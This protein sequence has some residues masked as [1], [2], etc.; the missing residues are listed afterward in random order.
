MIIDI[1][2]GRHGIADAVVAGR[3]RRHENFNE[4][5]VRVARQNSPIALS[6]NTAH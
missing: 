5:H 2:T 6:A 3:I 4:H 1:F